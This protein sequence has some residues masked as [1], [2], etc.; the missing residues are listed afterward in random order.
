MRSRNFL[1]SAFPAQV[2][3]KHSVV[4]DFSIGFENQTGFPC[5]YTK[6]FINQ[7]LCP[8]YTENSL[9]LCILG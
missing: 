3:Q 9:S 8:A 7:A 2:T 6:Y 1:V 4:P 5:L